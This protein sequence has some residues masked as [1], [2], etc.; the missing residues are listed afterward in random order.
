[1]GGVMLPDV[2]DSQHRRVKHFIK[3]QWLF[4]FWKWRWRDKTAKLLNLVLI[5]LEIEIMR[6]P[7]SQRIYALDYNRQLLR[8]QSHRANKSHLLKKPIRFTLIA[9]GFFSSSVSTQVTT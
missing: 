7:V 2:L 1:V 3:S 4:S 5:Y 9:S 6:D 8:Q